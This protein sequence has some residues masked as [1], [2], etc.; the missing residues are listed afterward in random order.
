MESKNIVRVVKNKDYTVINNTS[1]YDTKLSWKAKAIHV[2]MLSKPDDWTFHNSELT[3]WATDG[4][5]SFD[6]GLK[7]LKK[8]GYVKKERRRG[9]NGKFEWVTVVYEVPQHDG[10][11]EQ[12]IDKQPLPDSPSME[13][14]PMVEPY[15][16]KPSMENPRV[17][18]PLVENQGLLNTN[19]PSTDLL[20]TDRLINN[21]DKEPRAY[22]A[23]EKQ[24]ASPT[25]NAF[26]FY[27][28]NHFGALGSLI[29][30]KIEQWI[31]DLSE[32][33]VIH[34]MEKAV[35]NGKTNWG[36]VETILKDWYNKKLFT[37]EAVEAAD[38]QWKN[39]QIQANKQ[40]RNQTKKYYQQKNRRE[41]VVPGWFDN[42]HDAVSND[43]TESISPMDFEAE[44]KK[45]LE[46]LGK[47]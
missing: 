46:M 33:L 14:P 3:Q 19:I 27:E 12:P 6:T 40:Q 15:P 20:S 36:Y 5:T 28:Q 41:E 16:E 39:Q 30:F 18:K 17:E 9:K 2:F 35:L 25:Q 38:L 24:T 32:P 4:D 31:N 13:N 8:Y 22:A 7:E 10:E 47:V 43:V 11:Q 42:R 1:L 23:S 26:V 21:N 37:L 45:I 29:I 44:R 34:A